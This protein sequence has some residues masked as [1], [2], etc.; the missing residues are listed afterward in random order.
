MT[1][2]PTT[3]LDIADKIRAALTSADLA[4]FSELLSPDVTWGA[5]G[6]PNPTCR[7]RNQVMN[8]YRRGWEAGTRAT[9]IEVSIHDSQLLVGMMVNREGEQAERWQVLEVGPDGVRDIRGYEDRAS[10]AAAC[11]VCN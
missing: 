4:G 1:A 8:W 9:V 6:D 5:P 10:A 7:N 11:R 3:A 2:P